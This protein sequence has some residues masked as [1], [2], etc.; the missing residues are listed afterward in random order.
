[1][2]AGKKNKTHEAGLFFLVRI[3]ASMLYH[4]VG[5]H[6]FPHQVDLDLS[7]SISLLSVINIHASEA[8]QVGALPLSAGS[9]ILIY[10][11]KSYVIRYICETGATKK[12]L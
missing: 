10:V 3:P 11:W 5:L 12:Q 2:K 7:I 6:N 9:R 8:G 1:M 4:D